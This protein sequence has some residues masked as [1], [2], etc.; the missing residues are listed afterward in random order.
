ML[1]HQQQ[2]QVANVSPPLLSRAVIAILWG[3]LELFLRKLTQEV[4]Q[5]AFRF[6]QLINTASIV[7][8][9]LNISEPLVLGRYAGLLLLAAG[10]MWYLLD[11]PTGQ[12]VAGTSCIA[13]NN[14]IKVI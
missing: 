11:Q 4:V 9:K 10:G 12:P 1:Q 2:Q 8:G 7:D 5:T 3:S 13:I 14:V 6:K